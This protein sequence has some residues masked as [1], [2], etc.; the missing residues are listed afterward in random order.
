MKHRLFP[1]FLS[2]LFIA[3]SLISL[4]ACRQNNDKESGRENFVL[5]TDVVPDVILEAA[6]GGTLPS[7]TNHSLTP[8]SNSRFQT[9]KRV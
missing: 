6:S 4:S 1:Q 3:V 5:I 9:N 8:I 7:R 2:T